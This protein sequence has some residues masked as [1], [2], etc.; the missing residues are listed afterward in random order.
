MS[1]QVASAFRVHVQLIDL[2]DNNSVTD[3]NFGEF[4]SNFITRKGGISL[5][6]GKR[7]TSTDYSTYSETAQYTITF[8]MAYY[9]PTSGTLR[10]IFPTEIDIVTDDPY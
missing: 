6:S 7:L 4:D 1:V 9:I 8:F 2:L 5:P 10:I 3:I